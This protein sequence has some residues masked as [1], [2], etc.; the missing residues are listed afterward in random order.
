MSLSSF[1]VISLQRFSLNF[2]ANII[3]ALWMLVGSIRAFAWVK[4]T[5]LQFLFFALTAL[6]AN[7][8]FAWSAAE[9]GSV[10]NQQG[11]ISYL[12]WPTVI[13][14][15]G[16][17]LAKRS[18]NYTLV[19]VPAILWLTA[20]TMLALLQTI[21]QLL[22]TQGW[23]PSWSYGFLP[24]LFML[25]FLWQTLALLWIFARKMHWHW[26]ERILIL[27]GAVAVLT[28]WQ[29]NVTD[30]PIFKAVAVE[31]SIEEAAFYQ[32]P[33]LLKA[34]LA[35]V[36]AGITGQTDWFFMGVAGFADQDVFRSEI[37]Q[38]R[39]LFDIRFGTAGHSLS[40]INNRFTWMDE[41]IASKTSIL[42]GLKHI[43]KQMN[44]DEDVLFLAV[45]S[46]GDDG[47]VHLSNAPLQLDNLD[48]TWLRQALDAAGIRWRV[49]VVSACYSGSFI[50]ELASATTVIITAS[51]ADRMSFG[52]SNDADLTYFGRAFFAESLRDKPSFAAAFAAAQLRIAERERQ[53]GFEPSEPQ[54]VVGEL[55]QTALPAFEQVLFAN[56]LL[57]TPVGQGQP[58]RDDET[59]QPLQPSEDLSDESA[60][61]LQLSDELAEQ[62]YNEV[63]S[64]DVNQSVTDQ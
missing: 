31:P 34:A 22:G 48:A 13:V 58:L 39:Q 16:I 17:I 40:L 61:S 19:F 47:F 14:F 56:Q 6:G 59:M 29:K 55:M 57:D 36:D 41:P 2:A 9:Q 25:L 52:C 20:D 21:I 64:D 50:D 27:L 51:R 49:I 53:M 18:G 38:V 26:W 5:A 45:S 15:A 43:G 46:H 10:F 11:L 4:P 35:G 60:I 44:A 23:L 12:V 30:Q 8:L 62:L 37:M 24:T 42:A 28:M 3:A 1:K 32:Q 54:M 33:Q 63:S 7:V